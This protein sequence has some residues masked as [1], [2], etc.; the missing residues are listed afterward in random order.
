MALNVNR[1]VTDQFYRYKMP[2]IIAKVEGKGNG[3]KTVIVNMADVAK[4]LN[5]PP[6][7]T[8]KFFGCELGAQ[9]QVDAKHDRYI[10]NGSHAG[11]KL[12]L[13]LDSFIKKFV[14]CPEC[15]N[16]ET[17]LIVKK[18]RIGKI[19]KACGHQ[20]VVDM[21]HKLTTYMLKHPPEDSNTPKKDKD[22]SK[23][24]GNSK[25]QT[26]GVTEK[27]S[28]IVVPKRDDYSDDDKDWSV[29]TSKAAVEE[30]MKEL[31]DGA[32]GLTLNDDLE[33]TQSERVNMFH[34]Y[35]KKMRDDKTIL[36]PEADKKVMAEAERL[37]V[38]DKGPLI[39]GEVL[40]DFRIIDQLKQYRLHFLRFTHENPKAQKY[41]LGAI[42]QLCGKVYETQLMSKVP[43][44]LQKLYE[45]DIVDEETFIAWGSKPSKKYV[46]KEVSQE[47]L[48]K[49]APFLKW[50]AEAEEASD[51]GEEED[52]Q[53]SFSSQS[54]GLEV[55][56]VKA[57]S[58]PS[59]VEETDEINIDDI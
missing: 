31:T 41:L 24:K 7:Y 59:Y 15:E 5:R 26:N 52:V 33:K 20:A 54:T 44:I 34:S 19:C 10:V 6:T 27:S 28:E 16:P 35:V 58:T 21:R 23:G 22:K 57:P 42:E 56:P 2:P 18:E 29:D 46:P 32:K 47:L 30:R 49:A 53:V 17:N 25:K 50:L 38:K 12:Q 36:A 48:K 4:A 14:L 8:T 55:K 43:L 51:E 39:L 9:T 11:G 3:I 1:S 40:L 45:L 37:E 13:M